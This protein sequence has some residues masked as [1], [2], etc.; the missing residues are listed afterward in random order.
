M[1]QASRLRPC[2][3]RTARPGV[4]A[5]SAM[6]HRAVAAT[7]AAADIGR[8]YNRARIL[9]ADAEN[10]GPM[11]VRVLREPAFALGRKAISMCLA[12]APV[13]FF[14]L[15][16][17]DTPPTDMQPSHR[18]ATWAPCGFEC[19]HAAPAAT[20]PPQEHSCHPATS[21][22]L[23]RWLALPGSCCLAAGCSLRNPFKKPAQQLDPLPAS[24]QAVSRADRRP[25]IATRSTPLLRQGS[26]DERGQGEGRERRV[27]GGGRDA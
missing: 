1:G 24:S 20:A 25:L 11:Q 22:W 26:R 5:M 14:C 15:F 3:T 16:R 23:S 8:R 13:A 10:W 7:T 12:I 21:A 17:H 9:R 18:L 4:A 6:C 2:W 19:R 27:H